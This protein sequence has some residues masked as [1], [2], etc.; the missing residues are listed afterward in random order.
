MLVLLRRLLGFK[1]KI[2][3]RDVGVAAG[4]R[5]RWRILDIVVPRA[6]VLAPAEY[7]PKVAV[8]NSPLRCAEAAPLLGGSE[9]VVRL[10]EL[11]MILDL[12]RQGLS[13]TAI[14][15]QLGIDRKTVRKYI[16]RGMG[17]AQLPRTAPPATA[18]RR[19]PA[20]L[21]ERLAAYPV[22][23][24]VRL[25]REL[26]ERGFGGGYTAVKRAVQDI[27]PDRERR[28]EVR[29]ETP[30]GEQAQIDLLASRWCSRTSPGSRASSGCFPWCSASRG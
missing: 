22:L 7:S 14:A 25:L 29:F 30:P 17:S 11:M 26:R 21:R 28:F 3:V 20:V 16:A 2:V 1:G 12:H 18:H 9:S 19:P 15:R 10:G 27:R 8:G 23:S 5:L 6:D 24:A 4:W 13:P